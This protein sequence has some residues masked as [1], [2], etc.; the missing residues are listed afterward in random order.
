MRIALATQQPLSELM[1]AP[2][3]MVATWL[4]LLEEQAEHYRRK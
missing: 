3:E 4:E 2:D 1:A